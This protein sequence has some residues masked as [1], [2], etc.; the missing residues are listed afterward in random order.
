MN[1][2]KSTKGITLI[3][4]VITIVV[5]LIL[6]GISIS[7]VLGNNGILIKAKEAKYITKLKEY[8]ERVTLIVASEKTLKVTENKKARLLN[9]VCTKLNEQEWVGK[10]ETKEQN[11]ELEE[12][13]IKVTTTDNFIVITKIEDD[14]G[15]LTGALVINSVS[16]LERNTDYFTIRANATDFDGNKLIYKLYLK[17][18]DENYSEVPNVT[19]NETESGEDVDL[20]AIELSPYTVYQYK[21]EVT[22]GIEVATSEEAIT[23]TGCS[24]TGETCV[25]PFYEDIE[26]SEAKF[27]PTTTKTQPCSGGVK[28]TDK[29]STTICPKCN[30]NSLVHYKM[31]CLS[32]TW[33]KEIYKCNML[34]CGYAS[35]NSGAHTITIIVCIKHGIQSKHYYCE[36]HDVQ[37]SKAT[38]TVR[39][40]K[41]CQ[42]GETSEH[43]CCVHN[44]TS[45]HFPN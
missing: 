33:E 25:G 10:V 44:K 11:N 24:G 14:E 15:Q 23:G 34:N 29:I 12:N 43:S 45:L 7:A 16:V 5:L 3:A 22:D 9:L 4:L 26:C 39:E 38:H 13:E 6:S 32:C 27:C 21:I 31:K 18:Q 36:K 19:S 20:K 40:T 17:K 1:K 37:S 30:E 8:E 28:V 41:L 35:D 42:H 2:I